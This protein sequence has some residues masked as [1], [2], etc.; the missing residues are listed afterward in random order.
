PGRAITAQ[1]HVGS[2]Q[3]QVHILNGLV[4]L[5][6]CLVAH[7]HTIDARGSERVTHGC[8]A[9]LTSSEGAFADEFHADH[10]HSGLTD[11]AYVRRDFAHVS[12]SVGV[13]ILRVHSYA[14]VIHADHR[15]LEPL[16]LWKLTQC[17]EAVH[18]SAAPYHRMLFLGFEDSVLP[19]A[20]I[21]R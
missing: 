17:R 4:D 21:F 20:R 12:Q 2:G 19:A 13:V 3:R 1:K 9:V 15:H 11:L 16:V 14:F 7:R 5:G 6:G 10:A 8:L 18:R